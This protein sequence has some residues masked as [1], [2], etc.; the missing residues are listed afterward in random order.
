MAEYLFVYG[1][2]LKG[3]SNNSRLKNCILIEYGYVAGRL[4]DTNE[5]YPAA[6]YSRKEESGIYGELY[7]LPEDNEVLM[8]AIDN[9]EDIPNG[10]FKRIE[11]QHNNKKTY[12]YTV[13]NPGS[14]KGLKEIRSGSWLKYSRVIKNNPLAF[15]NNFEQSHRD[16]Y[17]NNSF[18]SVITIPGNSKILVS[19]PH[20]TNHVRLSKLKRF[21][22][23]TA[24]IGVLLHSY[25]DIT[26][27]YSNS[28]SDPDPNYYDD[29]PYKELLKNISLNAGLNFVLDLHGTG[30]EREADIYP[31]IGKNREFLLGSDFIL[32]GLYKS[33]EKYSITCGSL[34]K[35]PASKQETVTKFCA[36][37]LGIP[38]MQL[39]INRA[40]RQ[41]DKDP[42]K[43]ETLINFLVDFFSEIKKR[44]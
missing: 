41:P 5:G 9:Y 33:A 14:V 44:E 27:V 15:T 36:R 37:I 11:I 13:K 7:R 31:G 23:Y 18:E 40:Y 10:I 20:A 30:E 22:H 29:S 4:Y 1:T 32:D 28:V 26:A 19:S 6:Y 38:S 25:L 42:E 39:E 16:Y 12:I 17:R 43:F 24:A 21:E 8:S 2:L 35:F 34:D 3:E